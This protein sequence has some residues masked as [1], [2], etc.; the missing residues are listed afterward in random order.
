MDLQGRL[1]QRR[2]EEG[3][4]CD[5]GANF[6]NHPTSRCR[7]A[8]P[9]AAAWRG[10][11]GHLA[12]IEMSLTPDG[13]APLHVHPTHGADFLMLSGVL[14]FQLGDKVIT[15]VGVRIA[16]CA[17]DPGQS[18]HGKGGFLSS[19][20]QQRSP[21]HGCRQRR[22][23]ARWSGPVFAARPMR[24]VAGRQ[25]CTGK[26]TGSVPAS[27]GSMPANWPTSNPRASLVQHLVED[28]LLVR[29]VLV[30]DASLSLRQRVI[31][32]NAP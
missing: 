15:N 8:H 1:S 26:A 17:A 16:E 23:R 29:E 5:V 20:R 25:W 6:R 11:E 24:R 22:G 18:W 10:S 7:R 27:R 14:S 13:H 4:E 2:A 12:V 30:D 19:A 3:A 31:S 28:L 9:D 32:S 21:A